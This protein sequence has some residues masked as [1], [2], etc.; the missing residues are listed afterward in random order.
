[1]QGYLGW[2]N[3]RVFSILFK[4]RYLLSQYETHESIESSSGSKYINKIFYPKNAVKA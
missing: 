1:M 4:T 3:D 2:K